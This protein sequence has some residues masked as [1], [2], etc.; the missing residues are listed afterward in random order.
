MSGMADQHH[1][2]AGAGMAADFQVDL[3]HQRAGGVEYFKAALFRLFAHRTRDAV[4]AEDDRRAIGNLVQFFDEHGPALA[5]V[6]DDK[7][8]VDNFMAHVNRRAEQLQRP[9]HDADGAIDAGAETAW[10]GQMNVCAHG[11]ISEDVAL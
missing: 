2:A 7:A 6:I 1:F 4:G 11:V 5:Q 10:V 9:F 3:G 8:V